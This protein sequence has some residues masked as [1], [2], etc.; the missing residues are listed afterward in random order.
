MV[1]VI[2]V[3]NLFLFRLV[4]ERER[5]D[6]RL[7]TADKSREGLRAVAYDL[8]RSYVYLQ[9]LQISQVRPALL[10]LSLVYLQLTVCRICNFLDTC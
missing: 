10:L 2:T 1:Q 9:G 4:A 6:S 3:L 8:L 7:T 5:L